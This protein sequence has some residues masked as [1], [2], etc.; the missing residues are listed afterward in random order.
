MRKAG[1]QIVR[2]GIAHGCRGS[3]EWF[4]PWA[5]FARCARFRTGKRINSGDRGRCMVRIAH[6]R[7]SR[8]AARG[9]R[10][11]RNRDTSTVTYRDIYGLVLFFKAAGHHPAV[12]TG[13]HPAVR[14]GPVA[15]SSM[16]RTWRAQRQSIPQ[17]E[18]DRCTTVP[19]GQ[20]HRRPRVPLRRPLAEKGFLEAERG[21]LGQSQAWATDQ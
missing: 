11:R 8:V 1:R 10:W 5:R 21:R 17:W 13:R 16:S 3:H 18:P 14:N 6:V 9:R 7:A 19:V 20:C 15:A 2:A 4:Y 12:R